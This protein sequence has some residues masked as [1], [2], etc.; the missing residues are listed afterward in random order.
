MDGPLPA[1]DLLGIGERVGSGH[2][3]GLFARLMT[4]GPEGIRGSG[5]N[6]RDALEAQ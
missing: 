4:A 6:H 1:R 2:V 3:S 5:P